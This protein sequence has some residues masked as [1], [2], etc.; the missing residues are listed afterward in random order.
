[1]NNDRLALEKFLIKVTLEWNEKGY[2]N[3][4]YPEYTVMIILWIKETIS[5]K[6]DLNLTKETLFDMISAV[7]N[8]VKKTYNIK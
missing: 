5:N 3:I 1:V 7:E 2:F 8:I 6:W 4:I